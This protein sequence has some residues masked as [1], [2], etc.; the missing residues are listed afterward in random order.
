MAAEL[1]I[2]QRDVWRHL[3][4]AGVERRPPLD[5]ETLIRL[6]VDER[7]GIRRVADRLGVAPGTVEPVS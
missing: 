5:R 7:L 6:Y 3:D 2:H 4:R 1:G